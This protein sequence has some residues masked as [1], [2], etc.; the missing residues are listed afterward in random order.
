MVGSKARCSAWVVVVVRVGL[1]GVGVVLIS[2]QGKVVK[3]TISFV[4]SFSLQLLSSNK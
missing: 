3:Y 4:K 2:Y 1:V